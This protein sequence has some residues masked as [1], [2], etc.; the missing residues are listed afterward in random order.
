VRTRR[1]FCDINKNAVAVA[2]G[3][4][5]VID[6]DDLC[7]IVARRIYAEYRPFKRGAEIAVT[8]KKEQLAKEGK[9]R[10]TSLLA[11]Y[12]VCKRL[13]KLFRKQRGTL[14]NAPE[15]VTAFQSVVSCFFDFVIQH[16]PSLNRYFK[17]HATTP[18]D[19][20]ADNKNLFFRPIGL[21]L[22][23]RLYAHFRP[24]EKLHVLAHGLRTLQ[25]VNPGGVLDGIVWN[26]GRIEASTKARKAA[27]GFCLYLLHE[28][29]PEEGAQLVTLL[30]EVRKNPDYDLPAKP[31]AP[32]AS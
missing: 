7:A 13:K 4:K 8:E 1:L 3:D 22:L 11:V 23:A 19:E 24:R 2:E 27:V 21:E 32:P 5:V 15:N 20:R 16:E 6:E 30:R 28:T 14:E 17:Q 12:S 18:A 29:T 26:M 25:F 31:P 9:E 10:F